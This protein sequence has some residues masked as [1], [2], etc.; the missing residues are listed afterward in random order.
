MILF[1]ACMLAPRGGAETQ[2]NAE[3]AEVTGASVHG[4][5]TSTDGEV[6]EGAEVE[7][8]LSH[9]DAPA[10]T[11]EE[12]DSDGE[13]SFGGLT[14][15]T[16][17]LIVSSRG[18]TTQTITGVLQAGQ[19]FDARTIV[20]PV[21][22]AASEV[23][24][25]GGSEAD[26]AEAQL[27]L[28]EQQR[29]LGVFP[30]YYVSYDHEA[31]PLTTRQKYQLAWRTS[32]DPVTWIMTGAV[33]GAEQA[34]NTFAGYGQGAQGYA[35]RFGANYTDNFVGTMIGGA[36]LPS[37]FRQ[38][39]RYFYKGT[40]TAKSRVLYA[41]ANAVICKGDNGRWQMNYSGIMGGLAA[42]G[43]SNL[44]YPA[45]NRSGLEVSFENTL[46]GTAGSAMQ[47]LVQEFL[48]RRLTPRVPNYA[49]VS[50]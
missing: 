21:V 23:V 32:I 24:V 4:V 41:I 42:G 45:S 35:K 10:T 22:N 28:E 31:A 33:A 19:A 34:K 39:P 5:V 9:D 48:V 46:I 26:I 3:D 6:Y 16:F 13:F 18:F 17:K 36:I 1:A 7:L 8:E 11:T 47:N 38:D 29:V 25:S 30:N 40:G 43:I 37:W 50:H 27:N 49:A 44:Y 15:G 20:L 2:A 12:T 14:S